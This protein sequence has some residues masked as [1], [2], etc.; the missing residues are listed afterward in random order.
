MFHLFK[1]ISLTKVHFFLDLKE[2]QDVFI[3]IISLISLHWKIDILY[4]IFISS[5][6]YPSKSALHCWYFYLKFCCC[7]PVRQYDSKT[8]NQ[9][10][11]GTML[12]P[13]CTELLSWLS[14]SVYHRFANLWVD[15]S[16]NKRRC[17]CLKLHFPIGLRR[18][19]AVIGTCRHRTDAIACPAEE[20]K[21]NF[22]PPYPRTKVQTCT[23]TYSRSSF[24]QFGYRETML[25]EP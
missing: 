23:P 19:L 7:K 9:R 17:I 24:G 11:I 16:A 22:H 20:R 12:L 21:H 15:A 2:L 6:L 3:S 25:W 4:H 10:I 5:K 14:D 1:I 18:I 8:I 13:I